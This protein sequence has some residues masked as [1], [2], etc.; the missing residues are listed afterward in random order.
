MDKK[1][2]PKLKPSIKPKNKSGKLF[3]PKC[4]RASP[5]FSPLSTESTS[6]S[7]AIDTTVSKDTVKKRTSK[8]RSHVW[9][10]FTKVDAVTARCQICTK[11]LKHAGNTTNLMQHLSRKHPLTKRHSKKSESDQDDP[12]ENAEMQR[13]A[14]APVNG[15]TSSEKITNVVLYML[16]ID[17]CP[18][19]TVENEGFC[20][21]KK[22]IVPRYKIPSRR[23]I[24][25]YMDDKYEHL[26]SMFKREIAQVTAL[27]LTCDIWSDIS[28]RGYLGITVHYLNNNNKMKSRCLGV[29]PLD[30]SHTAQYLSQILVEGIQ[31][32]GIHR[33][34]VTAIV[35]DNDANIKKAA[36]DCFGASKHLECFVHAMSHIVPDAISATPEVEQAI[37][38]VKVI[39]TLT[40]RSVV[41]S[42]E[43]R[44]LQ[45]RDG[46]TE[47][48]LLKFKQDVPTRWNSTVIMIERFLE[49]HEYVYPISLK[50]KGS[51]EMPRREELDLLRDI[52][53]VLKPVENVITE[54][55]GDTYVTSSLIIPIIRCMMIAIRARSPC[56]KIGQQFQEKLLSKSYRRFKDYESRELL[57]ISTILDPQF[58][59]LHFQK[60]LLA[61]TAIT[62]INA[63][64]KHPS[65]GPT[66]QVMEDENNSQIANDSVWSFHD[67]LI[68]ENKRVSSECDDL[69][70]ELRQYLNQPVVSRTENPIE[71]W[72]KLGVA[73]PTLHSCALKYLSIVA[74]SVP[75]ER[76]FSKADAIKAE[77]RS[78]LTGDRL[79]KLKEA[80]A[81][82]DLSSSRVAAITAGRERSCPTSWTSTARSSAN[83]GHSAS[84]CWAVSSTASVVAAGSLL[85]SDP[86]QVVAEAPVASQHLSH[87]EGQPAPSFIDPLVEEG[88]DCPDDAQPRGVVPRGY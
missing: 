65:K 10:N 48:T 84:V 39:V 33:E 29:L 38:K 60:P 83:A 20:T 19:S 15:G 14:L 30:E 8:L 49:L 53:L 86:T 80:N 36:I 71:Y 76:L 50:C 66:M 24:T 73:Y 2:K 26:H 21:L 75:S 6:M 61:A 31:S 42:D 87:P 1:E 40:K 72:N 5:S 68:F 7:A 3:L 55:S 69:A 52:V 59:K 4:S 43:L 64:I 34:T 81:C 9:D 16:A 22:T 47:A 25:R 62:K 46:K 56:T 57:A 13:N 58:K 70:L 79:N 28:N 67:K 27:T 11:K 45:K 23:T 35:T 18:L 51:V 82:Q 77:R 88:P 63:I 41:V 17:N 74:T 85:P 54:C 37:A 32:F 78:R 44:R 12:S